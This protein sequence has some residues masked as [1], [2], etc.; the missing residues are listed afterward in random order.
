M[1]SHGELLSE[2][3]LHAT[4]T[5]SELPYIARHSF[6]RPTWQLRQW[7]R[8]TAMITAANQNG[9]VLAWADTKSEP[10]DKGANFLRLLM[11]TMISLIVSS[12]SS[13]IFHSH[14]IVDVH[15]PPSCTTYLV[16]ALEADEATVWIN[17]SSM[18]RSG[19]GYR[20]ASFGSCICTVLLP[21]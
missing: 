16:D 13:R 2:P 11:G 19:S 20:P 4:R 15:A 14:F 8:Q 9:P 10:P 17:V 21:H 18:M 5:F 7:K 12:S 1:S 3:V 6:A